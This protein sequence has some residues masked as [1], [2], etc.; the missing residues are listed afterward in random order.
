MKN[1]VRQ[2]SAV[3]FFST[4]TLGLMIGAV[5]LVLAPFLLW[6]VLPFRPLNVWAIDKTVPYPDYQEHAGFFWVLKNEK[7]S[8]PGSRR[9]YSE[10]SD[11]FGFYPYGSNEWRT[12]S[13]PPEGPRPDFIYITDTYGVY[14]DDYMQKRLS[15][16]GSSKIYG[17][18]TAED[19]LAI[20]K[21]LGDGNVFMAEF[22][23]AASPT[24]A[25]DRATLGR[26]LGVNWSGWI[27]KYFED[28]TSGREVPRWVVANWESQNGRTWE[29][30][31]RGYILLSDQ[32]KV[33][34]LVQGTDV[35]PV[36]LKMNF[37]EELAKELKIRKPISYRQWFEW[38]VPDAD[39]EILANY[40]IDILEPGKAKLEALGLSANFPAIVRYSNPQ[41]TGW[42]VA[43]DAAELK[44][45]TP[46]WIA[47]M[48]GLKK[49]LVDDSV[50]TNNFFFW[51]AYVPLMRKIIRDVDQA[52]KARIAA[53]KGTAAPS[54]LEVKVRASG[55]ELQMLDK[56]GS[57]RPFFVRG[58][59]IGMAMP[60]KY[61][62]DF[63]ND[64]A[65]YVRWLTRI[66]DMN[67]NTVRVYTLPPPEFYKALF[68]HNT[69]HPDR[70][71]YLLQE[72][73]PEENPPH[74]DYLAREYRDSYLTEID[75]GIDAIYGRANIPERKGRAWGIYTADVSRWLVGWLVG[76]EL[77]SAEVLAT[78][79]RNKGA[80][81]KGTYVS[82]GKNA[83]PTEVWL[84]ESLD[85]VAAI[86]TER[87][88]KQ[89]PVAIV[90]W[91]TL[92]PKEHD[93]EWDVNQG[94]KNRWNDRASITIEHFE[95]EPAMKAG[96]FG[97]YH[98]YPNYPDFINN[99]LAYSSY[100]DEQG[101]LRYGG[102]LK[103][104][105]SGITRYPSIVAEF[106]MANG[107]GISH[108]APDGLHHGGATETKA[109]KDILR[110]FSAM[111][112]EG[113]AGGL[114][115]EWMD[116]WV[117]KT[118]TSEIYMIPYERHV[119]WHNVVDAEQNYGLMANE[120]V[121][122]SIPGAVYQ[123]T[124]AIGS[125]EVAADAAYYHVTV[126]CNRLPDFSREELLVGLD[127]YSRELGQS[128]WPVGSLAA[129]SGLEFVVRISSGGKA[130]LLV[131]PSY[132]VHTSHYATSKQADGNFERLM[133]LVN[134][135]V[136]TR[137]GR[138][139]PE[140][141][142]DA[143]VLRKGAFDE[144]GNLW[145]IE[146]NK[147]SIRIPWMR[148]NVSDPSSLRVIRDTRANLYID[149]LDELKT[150]PTDGFVTAALLWDSQAGRK[151]GEAGGL[152][153]APYLW[154]GWEE[155]PKYVERLKKSYYM[156][157]DAWKSDAEAESIFR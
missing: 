139:I 60:G 61:F 113:Y 115:F 134:G 47:G 3:A 118:W 42:Y 89:H 100:T 121:P 156:L 9:L 91:P 153:A 144:A 19:V 15:T 149:Q 20:R 28:L 95:V 35:T 87:Y 73:W 107:A 80:V 4:L 86:E 101:M 5:V 130:D 32:D 141:Y 129:Q 68:I 128:R 21:N 58:V 55:R 78:D 148:I 94:K 142:F 92:D 105:I 16:E 93:S 117:K 125:V 140:Q 82:A 54:T 56:T 97:A 25:A 124:G 62:T 90:S 36:G 2:G 99:E 30:F 12:A 52:K 70:A 65:A 104:F 119:L 13:L 151:T 109:A 83:S 33:E 1:S 127:T 40:S 44:V 23:T 116:E 146:G 41:Y 122:P 154:P 123:G 66:A 126:N 11:Y 143:S 45:S 50:D 31:G 53:G 155:A 137:D 38:I 98:I 39:V 81:Y 108:Y 132:N 77:E 76:R 43:G 64:V 8:K 37:L 135:K 72:I 67:V 49:I 96:I 136:T 88:G 24:N 51:R 152:P 79:S 133:V 84:A 150:V 114:V 110:M 6:Q 112:K 75:Y 102:Y 131:L 147:I 22:N 57:W 7:I 59:N 34:V 14:K 18:L 26:L 138:F 145:N 71:L 46:S 27:G 85:E 74:E 10:K 120:V 29:F 63:P 69:E 106:G 103:E 111:K 157:R 17:G 48:A